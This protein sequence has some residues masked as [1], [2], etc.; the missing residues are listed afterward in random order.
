MMKNPNGPDPAVQEAVYGLNRTELSPLEETMYQSWTAA[1]QLE[2]QNTPDSPFDMRDIYK[3]TGGK[4]LP[5][6]ELKRK[7][8]KAAHIQTLMAAQEAHAAGSPIQA[9]MGAKQK[10]S[11]ATGSILG[12]PNMGSAGGSGMGSLAGGLGGA[13]LG[14]SMGGALASN[15]NTGV[16]GGALGAAGGMMGRMGAPAGPP[17]PSQPGLGAAGSA[18]GGALGMGKTMRPQL[19]PTEGI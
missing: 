12:G 14:G 1:N 16:M 4:V 3:Q 13:A 10:M 11:G 6:G 8:E 18:M 5:P 2:D 7:A 9:M 15:P 17:I 19:P